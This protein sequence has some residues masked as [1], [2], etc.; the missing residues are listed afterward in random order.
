MILIRAIGEGDQKTGVGNALH[1]LEKPFRRERVRGP[2]TA[3]ANRM[4]ERRP[5]AAL[6]F[7]N[8]SRTICPWATPDR[9]AVSSN[10]AASSFPRRIVIV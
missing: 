3:P 6:A 7:S 4:K 1:D 8:C 2:S 10:Q 9:L 5:L